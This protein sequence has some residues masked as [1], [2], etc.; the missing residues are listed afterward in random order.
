MIVAPHGDVD[1]TTSDLVRSAVNRLIDDGATAVLLDLSDVGYL[2]ST[3]LGVLV[4]LHRRLGAGLVVAGARPAVQRLFE[5]TRF[6]SV[7]RIVDS[8]ATA[9]T[10]LRTGRADPA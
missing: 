1:L 2:D 7:L 8:V 3:A 9:L 10:A 4:Q 5:I 6:T